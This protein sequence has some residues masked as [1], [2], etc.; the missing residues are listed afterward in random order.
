MYETII[1]LTGQQKIAAAIA[2]NQPLPLAEVAWG[3]GNGNPVTPSPAQHSLVHEVYRASI[4]SAVVDSSNS[5]LVKITA[6]IPATVGGWTLREAGIFDNTGALIMLANMPD[7]LKPLPSSGSARDMTFVFFFKASEV[8]DITLAVDPNVVIATRQWVENNFAPLGSATLATQ[9]WV[10]ENFAEEA[11]TNGNQY[12]R[13]DGAWTALVIPEPTS[14]DLTYTVASGKAVTAGKVVELVSSGVRDVE[15]TNGVPTGTIVG[16]A[17]TS[18]TAGQSVAV[19]I[20]PVITTSGL[21]TASTYFIKSDA[22]LSATVDTGVKFGFAKSA[23]ELIF[24]FEVTPAQQYKSQLIAAALTPD[25]SNALQYDFWKTRDVKTTSGTFTVPDKVTMLGIVGIGAGGNGVSVTGVARGGGGG[26]FAAKVRSVTPGEQIPY[27]I[28][29][30]VAS[31][32]GMTANPGGSNDNATRSGGAATGGQVNATGGTSTG[33]A[34]GSCGQGASF[35][36]TSTAGGGM[37]HWHRN[38]VANSSNSG[39]G[40]SSS[41]QDTAGGGG[42]LFST[43]SLAG[44]SG[45]VGGGSGGLPTA[46]GMIVTTDL[47]PGPLSGIGGEK[48]TTGTAKPGGFGSGGGFSNGAEGGDGG[49]GGG[50]GGG[51]IGG[52]GG[53]GGGG[54]A[55]LAGNGGNGGFG[56]GGGGATGSGGIPGAGGFGGGGGSRTNAG[57]FTNGG[58]AVVVF[59]Y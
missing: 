52:N 27:T 23:T 12:V 7:T 54:G 28:S 58:S 25:L 30:G 5:S 16:I 1:T 51:S 59:I 9:E 42:M 17:K 43:N 56:G 4:L 6:S 13:K 10:S 35:N 24:R 53:F 32:D 19:A 31:C 21:T 22:T 48:S 50:G 55:G 33:A 44:G 8:A 57:T 3:D 34:G 41:G 2:A 46:L 20:G 39:G 26:G 40:L 29:A 38:G 45:T 49:F 15:F 37:R 18:Q 47:T 14:A 11:P 36:T